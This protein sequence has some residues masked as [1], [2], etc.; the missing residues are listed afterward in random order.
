MAT[1]LKKTTYS[2]QRKS[3]Y[4]SFWKKKFI[5]FDV[6]KKIIYFLKIIIKK[7]MVSKYLDMDFNALKY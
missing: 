5:Y 3:L 1:K 6:H 7:E 2:I 4:L